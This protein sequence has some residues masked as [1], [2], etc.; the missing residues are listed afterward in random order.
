MKKKKKKM[1]HRETERQRRLEMTALY[2]DL[3]SKLP[4][5]CIQGKRS[6]C[7]HMSEAINYIK[8]KE[9]TI[10]ELSERRDR[11]IKI[12]RRN[13]NSSSS[14]SSSSCSENDNINVI[15]QPSRVGIEVVISTNLRVRSM[16][17][18][19][20][21]L[22]LL[23]DEGLSVVSC[24]SSNANETSVHNIQSEVRNTHQANIEMSELQ[25]KLMNLVTV[26]S[27]SRANLSSNFDL[28]N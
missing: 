28:A 5:E 18:L 9:K 17:P 22:E 26:S 4:L 6:I 11:L 20:S 12:C 19:S 1:E 13:N 8:H 7:D 16:L 14:S 23:L 21:V 3:R 2:K 10:K 24:V 25:Q 27:A 15:V